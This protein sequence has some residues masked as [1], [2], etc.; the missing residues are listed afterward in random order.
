MEL[1]LKELQSKLYDNLFVILNSQ[2]IGYGE[3]RKDSFLQIIEKQFNILYFLETKNG[4]KHDQSTEIITR[5]NTLLNKKF[6]IDKTLKYPDMDNLIDDI[7][8]LNVYYKNI[9]KIDLNEFSKK[10]KGDI[11]KQAVNV[12]KDK[13]DLTKEKISSDQQTVLNSN[14]A[15]KQ[16]NSANQQSNNGFGPNPWANAGFSGAQGA[17]NMGNIPG[18]NP[19]DNPYLI[20]MAQARLSAEI[21]QGSVFAYKSK[22]KIIIVTKI[23]TS[24]LISLLAIACL[25]LCIF[26]G[27][28]NGFSNSNFILG[29][30]T[31]G[32]FSTVSYCIMYA[33]FFLVFMFVS[34]WLLKPMVPALDFKNKNK[35]KAN[36]NELYYFAWPLIAMFAIFF[37]ISMLFG[38]FMIGESGT[39]FDNIPNYVKDLVNTNATQRTGLW[40]WYYT[41][42]VLFAI[43][44][45]III[46]IVVGSIYNPKKDL[47]KMQ[48]ILNQYIDE[49]TNGSKPF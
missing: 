48:L 25:V 29:D 1:N 39:I 41:Y 5:Y 23:I 46:P 45:V 47:E 13:I 26:M 12:E 14:E 40:G 21:K 15:A 22:P 33:I 6:E 37:L 9:M 2:K 30:G 10:Y 35:K 34:Y 7:N 43:S 4:S 17:Q 27:M 3:L 28:A 31:I 49:L 19:H 18:V 8:Y 32:K 11:L 24:I 44:G 20:G 16:K 42:I 38:M 36:P